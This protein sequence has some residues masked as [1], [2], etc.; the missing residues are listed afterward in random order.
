[1]DL[2]INIP[3]DCIPN[4]TEKTVDEGWLPAFYAFGVKF[5]Q[6]I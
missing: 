3:L 5:N 4:I 2:V 6:N 1:M